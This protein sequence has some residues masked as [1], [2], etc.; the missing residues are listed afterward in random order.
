[1]RAL[2]DPDVFLAGDL[3]VR[4]ALARLPVVPDVESWRPWRSYAVMQLW[5]SLGDEHAMR[6]SARPAG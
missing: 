6:A 2:G 4:H 5:R 1:M 3:G